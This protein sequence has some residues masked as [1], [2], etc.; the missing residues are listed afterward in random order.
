MIQL[1]LRYDTFVYFF[2]KKNSPLI[3]KLHCTIKWSH[4]SPT[5][6][7]IRMHLSE[8]GIFALICVSFLAELLRSL[9]PSPKFL[10]CCI[11]SCICWFMLL[12]CV[13]D[14][15]FLICCPK[16]HYCLHICWVALIY[17]FVLFLLLFSLCPHWSCH[18][19]C[20]AHH[21]PLLLT[22]RSNNFVSSHFLSFV[23]TL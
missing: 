4:S 3:P 13:A 12:L 9:I 19:S 18:Y 5:R 7:Y 11:L 21:F 2:A 15:L 22:A 20:Y 14:L 8:I 16:F 17:T 10:S 1:S 23:A 6:A